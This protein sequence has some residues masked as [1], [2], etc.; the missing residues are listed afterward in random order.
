M[1]LRVRSGTT[2]NRL[3]PTIP[4]AKGRLA[5]IE[6]QL[7]ELDEDQVA[8]VLERF[9]SDIEFPKRSRRPE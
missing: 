3:D 7:N 8:H 1:T 5:E 4:G 6:Q 2:A 9:A